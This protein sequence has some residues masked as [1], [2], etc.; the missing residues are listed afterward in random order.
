MPDVGLHSVARYADDDLL[1]S[2][3]APAATLDTLAGKT[4]AAV[5]PVGEGK[6]VYF[7]D[8][9]HYRMFWRGPSRMMVNGVMLVPECESR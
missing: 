3:Y 1:A 7:L 8:N 9:P 6:V 5:R 4:W 2:G